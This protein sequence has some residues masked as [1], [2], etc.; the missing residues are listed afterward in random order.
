MTVYAVKSFSNQ[1]RSTKRLLTHA[2]GLNSKTKKKW[3]LIS[4]FI[5]EQ[6]ALR[7]V[8]SVTSKNLSGYVTVIDRDR[9][10]DSDGEADEMGNR[11]RSYET[12]MIRRKTRKE[13]GEPG[14][15]HS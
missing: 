15:I 8:A 10:R 7:C 1:P 5:P 9:D 11:V 13:E 14:N 6:R 4:I 12:R 2:E 3:V